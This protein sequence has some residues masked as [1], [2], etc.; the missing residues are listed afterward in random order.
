MD[1]CSPIDAIA[2]DNEIASTSGVYATGN[3]SVD[4]PVG[5][6]IGA[7]S[8]IPLDDGDTFVVQAAF[9]P[10]SASMD[11]GIVAPNGQFYYLN[12]TG[13]IADISATATYIRDG[14]Y[15]SESDSDSATTL[16]PSYFSVTI[17]PATDLLSY[18]N[19]FYSVE[20]TSYGDVT[21]ELSA[22]CPTAVK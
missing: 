14:A 6:N 11:F 10:P 15:T 2:A 22:S 17:Y 20:T 5:E 7:N 3:F 18:G 1:S 4:I 9:T 8:T 16:G 19:A 13:G 12:I 21:E